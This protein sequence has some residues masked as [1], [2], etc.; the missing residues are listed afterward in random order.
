[1]DSLCKEAQVCMYMY[2]LVSSLLFCIFLDDVR[3]KLAQMRSSRRQAILL[4]NQPVTK[5]PV[6]QGR[7]QAVM[8]MDQL[9]FTRPNTT[10]TVSTD[11]DNSQDEES[12][13]SSPVGLPGLRPGMFSSALPPF[14]TGIDAGD[15]EEG[16]DDSLD[17]K[18][19]ADANV[20]V[21][22]VTSSPKPTVAKIVDQTVSNL[23]DN[24]HTAN[25]PI[26]HDSNKSPGPEH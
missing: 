26:P 15:E 7:R 3:L 9:M 20:T 19:K 25:S 22:P 17:D 12:R 18:H 16:S 4:D 24:F 8:P 23:N 14:L 10:S 1:M 11:P 6:R 5:A 21:G 13:S 2:V